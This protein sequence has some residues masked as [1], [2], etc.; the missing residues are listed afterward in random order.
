M[1]WNGNIYGNG[2]QHAKAVC[3]VASTG[4]PCTGWTNARAINAKSTR[5]FKLPTAQGSVAGV[6]FASL[7]TADGLSTCFDED[8][9]EITASLTSNFKARFDGTYVK[10]YDAYGGILYSYNTRLYWGDANWAAGQ[11]RIYCWDFALDN[12]CQNW[13][14]SGIADTNYQIVLDPY[15]PNCLW[16]NSHDGIIQT[17]DTA[18]ATMGNCAVPAPTAVFDAGA[19]LPRMACAEANAIQEWKSFT[20]TADFVYTSATLSIKTEAGSAI[21]GWTN[22]AIP[23]T[24]PKTVDISTLAVAASGDRTSVV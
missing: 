22:V 9:L 14:S 15:N 5:I 18:T 10:S 16:S 1:E 11:G 20:L 17:Y 4:L 23:S 2:G 13:T 3:V 12:W 24:A 8:G 19:A 6:C 21:T 7:D